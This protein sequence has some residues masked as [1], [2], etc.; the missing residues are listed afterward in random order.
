MLDELLLLD[1]LSVLLLQVRSYAL[2]LDKT[3]QNAADWADVCGYELLA[4][5]LRTFTKRREDML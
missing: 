5:E 1:H 3:G 4:A 2:M